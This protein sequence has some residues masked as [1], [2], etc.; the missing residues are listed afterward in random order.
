MAKFKVGDRVR[1]DG[2]SHNSA[3]AGAQAVVERT[4]GE[5]VNVRWIRDGL[6]RG[7]IDGGYYPRNF[8]LVA[9]APA[10]ATPEVEI[11]VELTPFPQVGDAVLIPG[12]ISGI[13]NSAR[14]TNYNIVFETQNRRVSLHFLEED[15]ILDEDDDDGECVCANND[16]GPVPTGD[17]A[18]AF[19]ALGDWLRTVAINPSAA[20]RS[21]KEAA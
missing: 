1:Y 21:N 19:D 2:D 10:A 6:D 12:V 17:T 16:N 8:E 7:Q 14:G 13:T 18:K 20:F 3:K 9:A 5:F 15:F 11:E 4:E